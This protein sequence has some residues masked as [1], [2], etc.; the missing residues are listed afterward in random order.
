M[1]ARK[2]MAALGNEHRGFSLDDGSDGAIIPGGNVTVSLAGRQYTVAEPL[3]RRAR[4]LAALVLEI[5]SV[6][7]KLDLEKITFFTVAMEA[8]KKEGKSVESIAAELQPTNEETALMLPLTNKMLD[9]CY[10]ASPAM[11]ADK[12][13]LDDAA[14]DTGEIGTAY[15]KLKE[16][17]M[18]PFGTAQHTSQNTAAEAKTSTENLGSTK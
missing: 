3:M 15:R 6:F 11:C 5:E 8:A 10:A 14:R 18:R 1:E 13:Y 16:L 7:S 4:E 9:F 17:V 2:D 12:D